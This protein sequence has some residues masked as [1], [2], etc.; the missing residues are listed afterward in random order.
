MP[1]ILNTDRFQSA[2]D[3]GTNSHLA[4]KS[5]PE[6]EYLDVV[7]QSPEISLNMRIGLRLKF[8][9][10]PLGQDNPAV[11]LFAED[12]NRAFASA[13]MV[14][15]DINTTIAERI[16]RMVAFVNKAC[17]LSTCPFLWSNA[18]DIHPR[19]WFYR[20]PSD[21]VLMALSLQPERELPGHSGEII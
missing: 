3:A 1:F 4:I 17:P 11:M 21:D 13:K 16:I 19:R 18:T 9:G 6:I 2:S 8:P 14:D 12:L 7:F 20:M 5:G 15:L 10:R